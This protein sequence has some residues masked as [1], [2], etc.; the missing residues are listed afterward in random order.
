MK[1]LLLITVLLVVASTKLIAQ[2]KGA[3]EIKGLEKQSSGT[4]KNDENVSNQDS[5]QFEIVANED[6]DVNLKFNLKTEGNVNVLV[7]DK[8]DNVV[9]SKK[10]QKQGENKITFTMEENE[11]YTVKLAGNQQSNLIVAISED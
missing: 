7:T 10:F 9:F 6:V 8:K 5:H 1:Q 2:E 3:I 4:I 11:K